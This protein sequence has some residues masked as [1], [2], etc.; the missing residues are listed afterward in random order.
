MSERIEEVFVE[1]LA[2]IGIEGHF[3]ARFLRDISF[4]FESDPSMDCWELNNRIHL[5]GWNDVEID[6]QT[7][8]LARASVEMQ[9]EGRFKTTTGIM[10]HASV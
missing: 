1:R 2:E 9:R 6:Y 10:E 4:I 3:V 5:L 8:E 7:M